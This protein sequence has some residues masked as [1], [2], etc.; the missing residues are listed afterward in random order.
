MER[1]YVNLLKNTARARERFQGAPTLRGPRGCEASR[2]WLRPLFLADGLDSTRR[3][4]SSA[5]HRPSR[6]CF[7][8][9]SFKPMACSMARNNARRRDRLNKASPSFRMHS[10]ELL[11]PF[12]TVNHRGDLLRPD[13]GSVNVLLIE[14]HMLSPGAV[15][16][17]GWPHIEVCE[18]ENLKEALQQG[19]GP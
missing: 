7:K 14:I 3:I 1:Y 18:E 4:S 17:A 11:M 9:G 6:P 8:S 10:D 19:T 5:V 15:R 13:A 16:A 2:R 12:V